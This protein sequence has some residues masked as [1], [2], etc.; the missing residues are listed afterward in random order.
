MKND[1]PVQG[2]DRV[3][4]FHMLG[5]SSRRLGWTSFRS[6]NWAIAG[7]WVAPLIACFIA[8]GMCLAIVAVLLLGT[9]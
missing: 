1:L 7:P 3:S 6:A 9:D 8:I 2:L 5:T 4:H